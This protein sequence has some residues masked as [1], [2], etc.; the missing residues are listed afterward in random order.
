MV[1]KREWRELSGAW[2]SSNGMSRCICGL[3]SDRDHQ[4]EAPLVPCLAAMV[5]EEGHGQR[6]RPDVLHGDLSRGPISDRYHKPRDATNPLR[7]LPHSARTLPPGPPY[8][9]L[10]GS[11]GAGDR[12][13]HTEALSDTHKFAQAYVNHTKTD[14]FS[15]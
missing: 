7:P 2:A 1:R 8:S 14:K 3:E 11:Q 6:L 4:E 13:S 5:P 15:Y 12:K 9:G 10:P